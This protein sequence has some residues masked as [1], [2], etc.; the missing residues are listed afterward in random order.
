MRRSL[1]VATAVALA[2]GCSSPGAQAKGGDTIALTPPPLPEA[3]V[4]RSVPSASA[5]PKSDGLPG[6]AESDAEVAEALRRVARARELPS[7]R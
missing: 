6:D 7:K 4:P 5:E 1:L 2:A 3:K